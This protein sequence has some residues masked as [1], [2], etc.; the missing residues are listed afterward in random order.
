[1]DEITHH[2]EK[3]IVRALAYKPTARFSEMRPPRTDS[4]LY[5][6]HLSKLLRQGFIAKYGR[7]YH[8]TPKGLQYVDRLSMRSMRPVLQSKITTGILVKNE[9]DEVVLSSRGKQPFLDAWGLP[10]GKTHVDDRSISDS[11]QR[12]LHERTNV[13][14]DQLIHVGDCYVKT[15]VDGYMVSNVFTHVFYKELLKDSVRLSSFARWVSLDDLTSIEM[16]PGA[17]EL[18]YLVLNSDGHFFEELTFDVKSGV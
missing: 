12:E 5:S 16:V 13:L 11:A 17:R 10:L 18:I 14:T 7:D 3:H 6:Y 1:M 2:I 9:Y 15:S 4:N 8:L